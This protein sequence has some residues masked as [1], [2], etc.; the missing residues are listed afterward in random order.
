MQ[1]SNSGKTEIKCELGSAEFA[2]LLVDVGE[3]LFA[4][5]LFPH[6]LVDPQVKP[7]TDFMKSFK[8]LIWMN[9]MKKLNLLILMIKK[10]ETS[11]LF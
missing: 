5:V 11:F 10:E 7:E 6:A 2:D 8:F 9:L 1:L 4:A 3:R